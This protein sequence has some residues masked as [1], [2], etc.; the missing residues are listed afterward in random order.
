MWWGFFKSGNPIG[1]LSNLCHA[2]AKKK[3]KPSLTCFPTLASLHGLI[4][5]ADYCFHRYVC[6]VCEDI[7]V[8]LLYHYLL[9]ESFEL[10]IELFVLSRTRTLA[11]LLECVKK[12]SQ[13][14]YD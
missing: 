7:R 5:P 14:I 10:N 8:I 1:R 2:L 11:Q 4:L 9:Q 6:G 13:F 12:C 3:K